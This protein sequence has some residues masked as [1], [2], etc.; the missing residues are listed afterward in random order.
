L[1]FDFKLL[2][3]RELVLMLLLLL[4]FEFMLVLKLLEGSE[5]AAS[6]GAGRTDIAVTVLL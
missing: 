4:T 3:L 2:L 5:G 6:S 1:R